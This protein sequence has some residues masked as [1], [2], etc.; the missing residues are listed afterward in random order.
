[1]VERIK[2][3]TSA[4][5]VGKMPEVDRFEVA[6]KTLSTLNEI[7]ERVKAA[8]E[9]ER[10]K[11]VVPSIRKRKRNEMDGNYIFAVQAFMTQ[12]QKREQEFQKWREER[13]REM[14]NRKYKV[15]NKIGKR[16]K[17]I[18]I[19]NVSSIRDKSSCTP[20]NKEQAE[21]K[22][23]PEEER[24]QTCNLTGNSECEGFEFVRKQ[25]EEK[26]RKLRRLF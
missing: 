8:L 1:M 13:S 20:E 7:K 26:R 3:T 18:K 19:S 9:K 6:K 21:K 17:T 16:S 23:S 5:L 10:E 12:K 25:K 4:T 11:A 2:S 14:E 24:N 22:N 15:N